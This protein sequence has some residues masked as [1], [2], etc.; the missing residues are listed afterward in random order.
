MNNQEK[1]ELWSYLLFAVLTALVNVSTFS[2]FNKGLNLDYLLSNGL[3]FVFTVIFAYVTFKRFVF[4]GKA[5]GL[6]GLVIEF[7]S[8]L[9]TRVFSL[10][11]DFS[12][13]YVLVSLVGINKVGSKTFVN[14]VI[15]IANYFINKY[16]VFK[17]ENI[18]K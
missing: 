13:M 4:K 2:V 10:I 1:R 17:K 15:I 14:I 3:A 16:I 5:V 6:K 8:F 12:T 7:A 11:F 18:Q 9:S